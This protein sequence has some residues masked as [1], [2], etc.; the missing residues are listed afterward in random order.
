MSS[1]DLSPRERCGA[2]IS[3]AST[4]S[5]PVLAL[6]FLGAARST[7]NALVDDLEALR[8]LLAA[9][10]EEAARTL[11]QLSLQGGA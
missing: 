8:L 10:E 5:D 6:A 3:G 1:P 2:L 9:R 4:A 11:G 7:F